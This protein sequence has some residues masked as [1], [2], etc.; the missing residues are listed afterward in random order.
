MLFILGLAFEFVA[1]T[2]LTA[3]A[4]LKAEC[5]IISISGV[6]SAEDHVTLAAGFALSMG[7]EQDVGWYFIIIFH[8]SSS[9]HKACSGPTTIYYIV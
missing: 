9:P 8:C 4:F 5:E 7:I 6:V 3:A 1:A 2:D